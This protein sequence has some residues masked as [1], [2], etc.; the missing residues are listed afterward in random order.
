MGVYSNYIGRRGGSRL[1][2]SMLAR[3]DLVSGQR[4]C[5]TAD[6]SVSG[7]RIVIASPPKPGE[8]GVLKLDDIEA[9]GVVVWSSEDCIG[10]RFDDNVS[11]Q[12]LFGLRMSGDCNLD[13][14]QREAREYARK[15]VEGE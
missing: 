10:F 4:R 11:E 1:R 15:W 9:F 5:L 14:E 7:A 12:Q 6:I 13:R 2:L 8:F 3:L